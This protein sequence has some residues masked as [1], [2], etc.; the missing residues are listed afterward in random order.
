MLNVLALV[1]LIRNGG[2]GC[3]RVEIRSARARFF[4]I[5]GVLPRCSPQAFPRQSLQPVSPPLRLWWFRGL[6]L[7]GSVRF[8]LL[9]RFRLRSFS[10]PPRCWSPALLLWFRRCRLWVTCP[11]LHGRLIFAVTSSRLEVLS[12]A[13]CRFRVTCPSLSPIFLVLFT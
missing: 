7:V 12:G 4:W 10:C 11:S 1:C 3:S 6:P 8:L 5:M 9:C 13:R 2:Q